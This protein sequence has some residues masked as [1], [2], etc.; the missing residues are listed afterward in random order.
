M[1]P[2]QMGLN[3]LWDVG[4]RQLAQVQVQVYVH[5]CPLGAPPF[6][7]S[8]EAV[9][10]YISRLCSWRWLGAVQPAE[11]A[12]GAGRG[13]GCGQH[14]SSAG[15]CSRLTVKRTDGPA[16]GAAPK[17]AMVSKFCSPSSPSNPSSQSLVF[18]GQA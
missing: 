17:L 9:S 7:C 5:R 3:S 2:M 16:S 15:A 12:C 6:S 4:N 8:L 11:A 14:M 10:G 13:L 1:V 18:L